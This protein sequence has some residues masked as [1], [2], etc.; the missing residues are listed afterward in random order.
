MPR[1]AA[2]GGFTVPDNG[3][4]AL[5]R[6]GAFSAKADDPSAI[7]HNVGGLAQ[8]TGTALVASVNVAM[9]ELSF[10]RSGVYPDDPRDPRTPW[11]GQ[12][13]PKVEGHGG[14]TVIPLVAVTSD[15]GLGVGLTI[16]AG[17]FAPS[18]IGTGTFALGVA[19]KPSPVRYDAVDARSIIAYPTLAAGYRVLPWLDVGLGGHL[20]VGRFDITEIASVDVSRTVCRSAESAPCDSRLHLQ[21]AGTAWAGSVGA[22]ARASRALVVGISMRSPATLETTGT[23][24]PTAPAALPIALA[25]TAARLDIALP[26]EA[27]AGVRWVFRNGEREKADVELDATYEAWGAAQGRGPALSTDAIGPL[28]GVATES[29][30]GYRSTGSVRLGGAYRLDAGVTLRLGAFYDA[31][32]TAASVT[33]VDVDTLDK[34]AVT[35]GV[36]V[37]LGPVTVNLGYAEVF[38]PTRT[39]LQGAIR[40]LN[41][42]R[43]GRPE[44]PD[45]SP[46]AAVNEGTYAAHA[47]VIALSV[48]ARFG[49]R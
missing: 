14:P 44:G 47:R 32:A 23:L 38:E 8:Q 33:R 40:P 20:V 5:G 3:A 45:G 19:G 39:V 36:G 6:G 22:I 21:T 26:W 27:R 29:L 4:E 49:N 46:Y 10:A 9:S 35:A 11:G 18:A 31:S 28:P 15:L 30:H 42:A 43:G 12:P 7:A 16:A 1:N 24:Q 17:L 48:G 25:A 37:E 2:A 41:A 13:F 34:V